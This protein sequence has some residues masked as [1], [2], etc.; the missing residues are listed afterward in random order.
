LIDPDRN[1]TSY[2]IP[3]ADGCV[4][5]DAVGCVAP[6]AECEAGAEVVLGSDGKAIETVCYPKGDTLSVEE[7]ES[8]SGN[9]AQNENNAVIVLDAADDGIDIHGDLAVDANNV[10]VYGEDPATSLIEG[11]V[12]VDGNNIIVRGVSIQGD[13]TIDANNAVFLH[14]VIEGNVVVTGNNAVI[15]A[16]DVFGSVEVRGNNTKLVAN[17]VVGALTDKGKNTHCEENLGA[18]D[19]DADHVLESS[20][21]GA[22][23]SCGK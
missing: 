16:C 22:A 12:N 7:V 20:E 18:S 9:I 5:P 6:R 15:A 14:C 10:V 2:S 3:E 11:D 19:A 13:V 23:L 17:H 4:G 8:K 21:L 1:V